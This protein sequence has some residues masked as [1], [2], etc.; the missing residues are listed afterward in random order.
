MISPQGLIYR[1]RFLMSVTLIC[2][3]CTVVFFVLSQFGE[4]KWKWESSSNVHV[5]YTSAFLT[6]EKYVTVKPGLR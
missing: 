1:F 2:A 6:G 5:E 3:L 4:S